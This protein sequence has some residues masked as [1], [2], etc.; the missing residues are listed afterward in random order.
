MVDHKTEGQV[1]NTITI[2]DPNTVRLDERKPKFD[3][4]FV[5]RF[6]PQGSGTLFTSEVS[7]DPRGLYGIA[8][9]LIYPL[10]KKMA[11]RQMTKYVLNPIKHAAESTQNG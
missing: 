3:A 2:E 1:P 11:I 7:L 9:P 6:T 8:A 5:N 4:T 10:V